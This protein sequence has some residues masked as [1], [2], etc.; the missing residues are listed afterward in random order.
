MC[1]RCSKGS[2]GP[3]PPHKA[4]ASSLPRTPVI[5]R[6]QLPSYRYAHGRCAGITFL[7]VAAISF[8]A[9][10]PGSAA[11]PNFCLPFIFLRLRVK[12]KRFIT[13]SSIPNRYRQGGPYCA[14]FGLPL[15]YCAHAAPLPPPS[16][17]T[18]RITAAP[19][20]RPSSSAT[21]LSVR[22]WMPPWKRD[23]AASLAFFSK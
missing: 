14:A 18:L 10:P 11:R 15:L 17:S 23:S 3:W 16:F 7:F 21:S 13:I 12:P 4:R 5:S 9:S 2:G 22:K 6:L 19:T 1:T 8:T 20:L